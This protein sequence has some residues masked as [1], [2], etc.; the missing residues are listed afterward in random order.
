[1]RKLIIYATAILAVSFTGCYNKFDTPDPAY[2]YDDETMEAMGMT[3]ISIVEIKNMFGTIQNT[4]NNNS[5]SDT[6]YKKFVTST[7][8][9]TE[10][11][12][13]E[14]RYILMPEGGYYI[15][16]KVISN[17]EQGNIYKSLYIWD[18]T[19]AIELKLTNGLFVEYFCDLDKIGTGEEATQWVYVKLE[20]L[21]LANFRMMLS[22]GDVPTESLNA[23]GEYKYYGN[24]NIVSPIK[25]SHHVFPGPKDVLTEGKSFSDDVYVVDE[26]SYNSIFGT[27]NTEKFLGR[28]IRFKNLTVKYHGVKRYEG[29]TPSPLHNG[30]YDQ[31]YPT[32]TCT[33]GLKVEGTVTYVVSRPW[34]KMAYSIDNIALYG[35]L[36]VQYNDNATYTSDAGVYIMRTSGYSRYASQYIP[37]DGEKGDVLAI[38][39]IYS[40]TSSY[41]GGERDYATYQINPCRLKDM[42]FKMQ[43]EEVDLE[44]M[45]LL[46]WAEKNLPLDVEDRDQALKEWEEEVV[47]RK[48]E[49]SSKEWNEWGDW[50]IWCMKNTPL[51]SI[52]LPQTAKDDDN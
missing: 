27:A 49:G 28:L 25:V 11:E 36:C 47:A 39:C 2:T 12:Q 33:S 9:L 37:K 21:Y 43:P 35:A 46:N 40:K 45:S 31:S 10:Y 1:M 18:G 29:D 22:I 24:S 3:P 30:S 7:D 44:W 34:Y 51:E 42:T 4:G 8:D 17:D 41:T 23:Y 14:K 16:G 50:A 38:Y 26:N 6:V 32:W 48:P 20:G 13:S 15:K 5:L 52:T 19:A